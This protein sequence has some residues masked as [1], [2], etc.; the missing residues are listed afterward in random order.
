MYK[1]DEHHNVIECDAFEAAEYRY[2]NS[3]HVGNDYIDNIRVSTVFLH[4]DHNWDG[5]TPVLFETMIFGGE[6][7]G[8]QE[9]YC[10]WDEAV[11]G[12][13]KA[14]TLVASELKE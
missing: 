7:D 11:I 2:S 12:H 4:M 14:L 13:Q 10:T 8:F 3:V 1:L 9:R 5:G 6:H